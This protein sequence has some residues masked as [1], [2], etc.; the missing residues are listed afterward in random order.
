DDLT[1]VDNSYGNSRIKV[2]SMDDT[3]CK[4]YLRFTV[5]D[6]PGT[7]G[8]IAAI[9]GN[10]NVSLASVIQK[11]K[12]NEVVPLVF[13]THETAERNMKNAIK[14]IKKLPTVVNVDNIIRVE[15]I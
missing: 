14:E 12:A 5:N 11:G 1:P 3:V 9:F 15:N 6:T 2:Q 13:V 7:L 10:N 8:E 4:Y